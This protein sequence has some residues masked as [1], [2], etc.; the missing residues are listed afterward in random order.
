MEAS[1]RYDDRLSLLA[2]LIYSDIK[3]LAKRRGWSDAQDTFFVWT[4]NKSLSAVKRAMS[5]LKKYKLITT[6]G[7]GRGRKIYLG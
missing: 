1:V 6:T 7:R 2:R 3:V 5:Q 4:Y